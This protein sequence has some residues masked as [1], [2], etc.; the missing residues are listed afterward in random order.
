MVSKLY[1]NFGITLI[2]VMCIIILLAMIAYILGLKAPFSKSDYFKLIQAIQFS[3]YIF[4]LIFFP[5]LF[6]YRFGN[7]ENS[8]SKLVK[9]S[10]FLMVPGISIF[11]IT[12]T[13]AAFF[14]VVLGLVGGGESFGMA[15]LF[16]PPLVISSFIYIIGIIPLI[17]YKIRTRN[18]K[19][20]SLEKKAIVV[21]IL[22][23]IFVAINYLIS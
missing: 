18:F 22:L 2:I 14:S 23:G 12:F 4:I 1:K 15:L 19:L 17:I 8:P 9:L 16:G 21:I 10:L 20:R 5:G 3:L 13:I 6:Y 7:E 11:L